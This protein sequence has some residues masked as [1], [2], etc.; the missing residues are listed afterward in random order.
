MLN[1][2]YGGVFSQLKVS[3]LVLPDHREQVRGLLSLFS[4]QHALSFVVALGAWASYPGTTSN[5]SHPPLPRNSTYLV[6]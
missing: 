2:N 1:V 4:S 3:M 5:S 6:I